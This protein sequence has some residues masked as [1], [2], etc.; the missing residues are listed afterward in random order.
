VALAH[1]TIKLSV[2]ILGGEKEA[3]SSQHSFTSLD[4]V[5]FV[6]A[7]GVHDIHATE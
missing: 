6:V 1:A 7:P 4:S 2:H 3:H 5:G